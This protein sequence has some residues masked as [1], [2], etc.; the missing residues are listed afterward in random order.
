MLK[1]SEERKKDDQCFHSETHFI[2]WTEEH[3]VY[4]PAGL[5]PAQT[6]S[7]GVKQQVSSQINQHHQNKEIIPV[8]CVKADRTNLL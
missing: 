5:S 2:S 6:R 3:P 8:K 1:P 7:D 4:R